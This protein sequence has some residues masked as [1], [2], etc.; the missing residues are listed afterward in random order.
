MKNHGILIQVQAVLAP[1]YFTYE[2]KERRM[3]GCSSR[4]PQET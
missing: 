3:E 4:F 2:I 1:V